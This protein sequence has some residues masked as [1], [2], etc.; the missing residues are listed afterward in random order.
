[1]CLA[2]SVFLLEAFDVAQTL[3]GRLCGASP[4]HHEAVTIV[5]NSMDFSSV[6]WRFVETLDEVFVPAGFE[7]V[8]VPVFFL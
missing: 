3:E 7:L 5:K 2:V 8:A 1:M 4:M 6:T